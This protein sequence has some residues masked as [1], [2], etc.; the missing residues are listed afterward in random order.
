M[1]FGSL[2]AVY[3]FF[4]FSAENFRSRFTVNE[5]ESFSASF[6]L[7]RENHFQLLFT[8]ISVMQ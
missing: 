4:S 8:V 7:Q 1:N 3:L 2:L 5:M 6:S